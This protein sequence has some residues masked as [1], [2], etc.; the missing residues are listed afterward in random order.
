MAGLVG[1]THTLEKI[2]IRNRAIKHIYNWGLVVVTLSIWVWLVRHGV[3]VS[4]VRLCIIAVRGHNRL[5]SIA[6]SL[7]TLNHF[8]ERRCLGG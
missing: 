2:F 8:T 3:R 4:R 6:P 1:D 7:A 5:I